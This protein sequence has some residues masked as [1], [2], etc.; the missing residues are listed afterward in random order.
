MTDATTGEKTTG[1]RSIL[2]HPAVY[3]AVQTAVGARRWMRRYLQERVVATAGMKILDI[4]CGPGSVLQF[5]PDVQ[6]VGFDHCAAYINAATRIYGERGQFFCDDVAAFGKYGVKDFDVVLATG[7]LHHLDD[8]GAVD[9]MTLAKSALRTGGHLHTADPCLFAGQPAITQFIIRRD[10]G[11]HVR[12]PDEYRQLVGKIFKKSTV[13][14][15]NGLLP[16]PH[17]VCEISAQLQ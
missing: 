7:I 3:E 1:W 15:E 10:R 16:F 5:L 12:S 9:L 14:L 13:H 6:Y 4:G 8:R 2:S 17:S 11:Q